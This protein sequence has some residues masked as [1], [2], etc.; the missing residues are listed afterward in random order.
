MVI[1]L[2][3][4]VTTSFLVTIGETLV[5]TAPALGLNFMLAYGA[6]MRG[7]SVVKCS[8]DTLP[9][10]TFLANIGEVLCLKDMKCGDLYSFDADAM[11]DIRNSEI[12]LFLSEVSALRLEDRVAVRK[13]VDKGTL[14][15]V[16]HCCRIAAHISRP[17]AAGCG[18]RPGKIA[19]MLCS[20]S[21]TCSASYD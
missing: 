8:N 18:Q 1:I 21:R 4:F 5:D 12:E 16:Q 7:S 6:Q 14:L 13:G 9:A 20:Y 15:I 19:G 17:N 3:V 11:D 10:D 2:A